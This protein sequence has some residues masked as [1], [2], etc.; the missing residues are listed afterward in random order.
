MTAPPARTSG[1]SPGTSAPALGVGGHLTALRRTAVGGF[2]LAEAAD[3]RPS[4]RSARPTVVNLPLDAAA[5][6]VLPRA[7]T[8]APH[9]AKVLSHGGPLDPAGITG[10]YAVFGPAAA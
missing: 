3:P 2:T 4:W 7:G 6:P 1:R 9:E 8:P 10:P 5:A